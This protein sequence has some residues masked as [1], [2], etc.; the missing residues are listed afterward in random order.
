MRGIK[1]NRESHFEPKQRLPFYSIFVDNLS[2][3]SH[4]GSKQHWTVRSSGRFWGKWGH[5][6]NSA[7]RS[8]FGK[9]SP[10]F[11]TQTLS[12]FGSECEETCKLRRYSVEKLENFSCR[13]TKKLSLKALL[14]F[15]MFLVRTLRITPPPSTLGWIHPGKKQ[16][17]RERKMCL[18]KQK[19]IFDRQVLQKYQSM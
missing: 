4:I 11:L 14:L 1:C 19:T 8:L 7:W 6:E 10:H 15:I 16:S 17:K 5:D 12:H 2:R 13:N 18:R 3:H 9:N